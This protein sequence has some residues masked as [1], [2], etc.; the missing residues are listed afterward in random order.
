MIGEALRLIRS[1]HDLNQTEMAERINIS[2]SYLSEIEGGKKE[3]SLDI[4]Q[5]YA[6]AFKIPASA[7]L[8]FSES[9]PTARRGRSVKDRIAG[10]ALSILRYI[11]EKERHA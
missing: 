2:K 4:L 7:I 11:E 3:P 5:R 8:L 1:F 6:E 10:K 9:I